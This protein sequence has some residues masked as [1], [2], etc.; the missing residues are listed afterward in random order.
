MVVLAPGAIVIHPARLIKVCHFYLHF[1]ARILKP[2]FDIVMVFVIV[3]FWS[4]HIFCS[5]A[6]KLL[7]LQDYS[8]MLFSGWSLFLS[9]SFIVIRPSGSDIS[10]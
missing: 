6:S 1:S 2:I 3:L 9:F 8:M 7:N 5:N 4:G 10:Q